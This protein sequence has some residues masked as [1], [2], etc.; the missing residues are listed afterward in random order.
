[1]KSSDCPPSAKV[2]SVTAASR[3]SASAAGETRAAIAVSTVDR[4]NALVGDLETY[5]E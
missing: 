1:M 5:G 4:E 2:R 3:R